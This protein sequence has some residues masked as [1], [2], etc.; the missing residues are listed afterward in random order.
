V[1]QSPF[2]VSAIIP[3]A[4]SG[5]R[6]GEAKQFKLFGSRPLLY[7]TIR[8]FIDSEWIDETIFVVP[9]KDIDQVNREVVSLFSTQKI[10]IVE[11]GLLRQDSVINGIN[12]SS[13][14]SECVCIHD[15]A[16]PFVT[17]EM[18]QK[19]IEKCT[20]LDGAIIATPVSDTLKQ[21][22]GSTIQSTIDRTIM[23]QAQT[24]QTFHKDRLMQAFDL[25]QKENFIGTDESSIMENAGFTIGIIEGSPRNM[26]IT[27]QEDWELAIHIIAIRNQN[28]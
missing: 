9:K 18:I 8:P 16:R 21:S 25:A 15:A 12:A 19:S 2:K 23:W 22:D 17:D 4:G 1:N 24:P 14:E 3:A 10:K 20:V 5:S 26:K 13:T 7:Y 6:F 28:D 27:T 11:G